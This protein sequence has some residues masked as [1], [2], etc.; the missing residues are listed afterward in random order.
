MTSLK[1]SRVWKNLENGMTAETIAELQKL[2]GERNGPFE[3]RG[4]GH[5]RGGAYY[6]EQWSSA[7]H[8]NPI[9]EEKQKELRVQ[10]RFIENRPE[11]E[12]EK[13][14]FERMRETWQG[15]PDIFRQLYIHNPEFFRD[16]IL[17]DG[18]LCQ[19]AVESGFFF[20]GENNKENGPEKKE[21]GK[22]LL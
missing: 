15:H 20:E 18:E 14:D 21:L 3:I 7:K 13:Y 22:E 10:D 11:N 4:D 2:K 8:F 19:L 16:L 9:W 17:K 1:T 6:Q 5:V 12:Q